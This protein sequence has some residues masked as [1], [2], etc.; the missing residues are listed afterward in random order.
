MDSIS[1]PF[2]WPTDQTLARHMEKERKTK[3]K[4]KIEMET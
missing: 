4:K 1:K 3:K 2:S